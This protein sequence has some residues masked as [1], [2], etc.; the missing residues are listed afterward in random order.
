MTAI[1]I[2]RG[3]EQREQGRKKKNDLTWKIFY[4]LRQCQRPTNETGPM[5]GYKIGG[6]PDIRRGTLPELREN[7]RNSQMSLWEWETER[8]GW[9][10]DLSDPQV[11]YVIQESTH[12]L[13]RKTK[14]G[15]TNKSTIFQLTL[16]LSGGHCKDVSEE[17]VWPLFF[18]PLGTSRYS[19]CTHNSK[20]PSMES[21]EGMD[22]WPL[23]PGELAQMVERSLRKGR[24]PIFA[25]ARKRK[26][27]RT[28]E[29]AEKFPLQQYSGYIPLR[30][31]E[32]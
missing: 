1:T 4:T 2:T 7:T 10:L 31:E 15:L 28:R 21:F 17:E 22:I 14:K 23:R 24:G 6:G 11:V 27:R 9:P 13:G 16:Q 20:R 25:P 30:F 32:L 29:N 12:I 3:K 26:R 18:E 19:T 5:N 8:R